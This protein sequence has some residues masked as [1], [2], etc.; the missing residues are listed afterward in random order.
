VNDNRTQEILSFVRRLTTAVATAT[1]YDRQHQQV[2]YLCRSALEHLQQIFTEQEEISLL[3]VEGELIF[4]NAPL[5]TDLAV[6]KLIRALQ[7][8][9][10]G[11]L[12]FRSGLP[13]AELLEL[14]VILMPKGLQAKEISSSEHIRFGRVEVHSQSGE[15]GDSIGELFQQ[16]PELAEVESLELSK[17]MDL[18][19][20]VRAGRRL[21]VRGLSEIVGSF[22][23]AF[24]EQGNPLIA[25]AP[26]RNMDEY[27]Y[28]HSTNVCILNIAQA[29][30]LGIEGQALHD[31]G[32]AAMLHDIGK[33]FVPQEILQKPGKLDDKEWEL[34]RDHPRLGAEYLVNTPGIPRLA[35][36]T[37]Y[38][39]HLRYD[40]SGYPKVP[41]NWQQHPTSQMTTISDFFDALR[42]H[43]SYRLGMDL[44][45]ISTIML[46][47]AGTAL[48]PLLTRNLLK[49]VQKLDRQGQLNL[50]H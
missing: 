24:S 30:M 26:L 31:I 35:V 20:S 3:L 9:G 19:Q 43:R 22:V 1:L 17:F 38:E 15:Q 40:Q 48:H 4:D 39:H 45:K 37:A 25:L 2:N 16:F 28:T 7:Q 14:I 13:Q 44:D 18:Y 5:E 23:N 41:K 10:I 42:T 21:N 12:K 11:H 29:R 36:I 47:E 49:T 27:T 33:L 46:E 50:R 32:I 34:I 6:G 8:R